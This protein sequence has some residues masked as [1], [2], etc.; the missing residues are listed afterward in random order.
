MVDVFNEYIQNFDLTEP[1]IMRKVKHS[2]KVKNLIKEM[3]RVLNWSEADILICE[4]IGF[5]HDIGRFKEYTEYKSYVS[6]KFDHGDYGVN[7]LKENNLY[8]KFGILEENKEIIFNAIY[9][10]NKLRVPDEHNDKFVKL[11]RDADKIENLMKLS[12]DDIFYNYISKVYQGNIVNEKVEAC[13]NNEETVD[14]ADIISLMDYYVLIIAFVFDIN[15]DL[16]F[17]ML[18]EEK[19]LERFARLVPEPQIIDKYFKKAHDFIDRRLAK[20]QKD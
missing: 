11:I 5:L 13:F 2:K 7:L 10:H 15:Y 17:K 20:I 6:G 14:L 18:K 9:Y 19:V 8:K 16:S 1:N 4:Q 3:A 12:D